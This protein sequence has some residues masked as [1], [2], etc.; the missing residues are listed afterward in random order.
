M[1]VEE[2]AVVVAL[3]DGYAMIEPKAAT[4]CQSCSA[5]STCGTGILASI[6][7]KR[8]RK[9][10]AVNSIDA[11]CG[12]EVMVG[13]DRTALVLASVMVYL[14]P[15]LMLVLGA[16]LALSH[17]G[18]RAVRGVDVERL[19]EETWAA[20]MGLFRNMRARTHSSSRE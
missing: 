6:F 1:M 10:R 5:S 4:G 7:G 17:S 16:I 20:L 19:S 15:L 14:L 11:R 12:D 13:L 9:L 2:Q 3:E 8:S 18:T